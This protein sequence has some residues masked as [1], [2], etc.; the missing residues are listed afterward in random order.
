M[1]PVFFWEHPC[2][3]AARRKR[4]ACHLFSRMPAGQ[5]PPL[6]PSPPGQSQILVIFQGFSELL[7]SVTASA[8]RPILSTVQGA[9]ELPE[10]RREDEGNY[11]HE[12]PD[13]IPHGFLRIP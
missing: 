3:A 2:G 9:E 6:W 1:V 10:I 4:A 8:T 5:A 13:H 12:N 7:G 11:E